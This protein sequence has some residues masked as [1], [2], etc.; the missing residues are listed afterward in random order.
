MVK[1]L[2]DKVVACMQQSPQYFDTAYYRHLLQKCNDK[3]SQLQ[4]SENSKSDLLQ[5]MQKM[6]TDLH[7]LDDENDNLDLF[8]TFQS[9]VVED[10]DL[11]QLWQQID[12]GRNA[13][14]EKILAYM[15]DGDD[16]DSDAA[17]SYS[18]YSAAQGD[19]VVPFDS[20]ASDEM[21]EDQNAQQSDTELI[22]HSLDDY[23]DNQDQLSL[24]DAPDGDID[25]E[26]VEDDMASNEEDFTDQEE[27][28]GLQFDEDEEE[29]EDEEDLDAS[30]L[31]YADF[32]APPSR[33]QDGSQSNQIQDS[34]DIDDGL[35]L[36]HV[37]QGNENGQQFLFDEEQEDLSEDEKLNLL[38]E[39]G[40]QDGD[41]DQQELTRFQKQQLKMKRTIEK[42]EQQN[43]QKKEWTMLGE[44][45]SKSR[46]ENSLLE[47]Q[48]EFDHG[49]KP[50][51]IITDDFTSTIESM[52]KQR[53]KDAVFDD[54]ERK[55][56]LPPSAQYDA[57]D[58]HGRK[59]E[60]LE[61]DDNQNAQSLSQM[62][63]NEYQEARAAAEL[64]GQSDVIRLAKEDMLSQSNP[65]PEHMEI[66]S[67]FQKLCYNLDSLTQH[68][69]VPRPAEIELRVLSSSTPAIDMEEALP[70]NV[71]NY[72]VLAPQ[73]VFAPQSLADVQTKS[74]KKRRRK[75][76]H[77]SHQKQSAGGPQQ[78]VKA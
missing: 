19:V 7:C 10:M 76:K 1:T 56:E 43:V 32:F 64:N 17:G 69:F 45:T 63:E 42:L 15:P 8:D 35:D 50:V 55:Y 34:L 75:S 41:E 46:P 9:L 44:A 18:R 71:S 65:K 29:E 14:V 78:T 48:L 37:E 27:V 67:L 38:L 54:V 59:R 74:S 40:T 12:M 52:I 21:L 49:S 31:M 58:R 60:R 4:S 36:E 47:H 72:S 22:D 5:F 68:H 11:N 3:D 24:S 2:M 51:P 66:K 53:I 23:S 28:E 33:K 16:G 6:F 20:D 26:V 61:I 39:G 30:N 62:Y 57:A 73:E 13:Y 70:V 77:G 25:Q